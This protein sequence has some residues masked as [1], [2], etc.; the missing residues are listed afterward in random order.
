[1]LILIW[2]V[3]SERPVKAVL[4]ELD[5]NGA[6]VCL[7]EQRA[8]LEAEI[9]LD[10]GREVGGLLRVGGRAIDLAEISACYLRP[11]AA[12]ELPEIAR[13]GPESAAW[14]HAAEMQ[15]VLSCWTEITPALVVNRFAAMATNGS[16]PY[17]LAR[18]RELGFAVPETIVTTAP[19]AVRAFWDRHGEVVYKSVSA[20]RSR[21]SRLTLSHLD[22]LGDVASCPTQFQQYIPGTDYR[23]HVVGEEVFACSVTSGA[24]DY[25]YPGPYGVA[26]AACPL[27]PEVEER[28]RC[29]AG[30]MDLALAG[31]DL[32][33]SRVDGE[34][35]CFE[36][37][38]SP[39]FSYYEEA[40]G[41]PI[42]AAIARLLMAGGQ[43]RGAGRSA[44]RTLEAH[45]AS[46][47]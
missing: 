18:I 10:V 16:K 14:R 33:R 46:P 4:E 3:A 38:P 9:E 30:A 1:V 39:G 31:I 37:N 36:V 6:P 2:G 25:R 32:R 24:D 27:P 29:L 40:T 34:W 41:V 26:L 43:P 44:I 5:R 47:A 20:V 42:G 21:V 13:A 19:E 23:V 35:Y 22:R 12:S 28:C 15:D 7:I 17:Q 8:V 11:Y 45:D